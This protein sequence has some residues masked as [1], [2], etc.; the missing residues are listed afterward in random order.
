MDWRSDRN[1]LELEVTG[2]GG[3]EVAKLIIMYI[4]HRRK[5]ARVP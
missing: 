5:F 1:W 2:G 3:I 4:G